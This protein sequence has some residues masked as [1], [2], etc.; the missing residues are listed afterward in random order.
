MKKEDHGDLN[1]ECEIINKV[2]LEITCNII[3]LTNFYHS[4]LLG[5]IMKHHSSLL[6]LSKFTNFNFYLKAHCINTLP[7]NSTLLSST[8]KLK[9]KNYLTQLAFEKKNH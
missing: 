2:N 7:Y 8:N 4:I 3:K 5:K 6:L 9:P 1:N